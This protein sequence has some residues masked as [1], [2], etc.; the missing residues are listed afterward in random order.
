MLKAVPKGRRKEVNI[1][2]GKS[3]VCRIYHWFVW[4]G[5][6]KSTSLIPLTSARCQDVSQLKLKLP[7]HSYSCSRVI[8]LLR[9]RIE[10]RLYMLWS[11]PERKRIICY[12]M[13]SLDSYSNM[14]NSKNSAGCKNS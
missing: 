10:N 13:M 3:R 5:H 1:G 4:T 8:R 6:Y 9:D 14:Y 12:Y 11:V 2:S 7:Y